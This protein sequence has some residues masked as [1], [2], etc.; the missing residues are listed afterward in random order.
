MKTDDR[1]LHSQR[2]LTG[3]V[4]AALLLALWGGAAPGSLPS[5]STEPV[6]E[7]VTP[8]SGAEGTVV[9][10]LGANFGPSVG[11]VQGTSGVSFNGV[12]STA[13]SWSDTGIQVPVPPGA[14]TGEWW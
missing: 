4:L 3:V 2:S 11:A 9:T 14:A 6:I 10:I 13:N 8:A 5:G 12:W 7:S 1:R